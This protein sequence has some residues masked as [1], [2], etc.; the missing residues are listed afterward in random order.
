MKRIALLF[1]ILLLSLVRVGC[2]NTKTYYVDPSLI[3]LGETGSVVGTLFT[4][5]VNVTD[6]VN[7][8]GFDIQFSWNTTYLE[9]WSHVVKVPV[10]VYADGVLHEPVIRLMDDVDLYEGS[11]HVAYASLSSEGFNGSGTVFEMTFRVINQPY[12]Y[13]VPSPPNDYVSLPLQLYVQGPSDPEPS[14]DGEVRLYAIP[15]LLPSYPLLK[16][17]PENINGISVNETVNAE[18]W[19]MG[20]GNED[21][22]PF[23]DVS[24]FDVYLNFNSTVIEAVSVD[25]DPDGWFASFWEGGIDE[26]SAEIDNTTGSVRVIFNGTE[27]EHV[28]VYGQG[29]VFNVE[30]K[31]ILESSNY[32]PPA[33]VVGLRNPPPRPEICGIEAP[34]YVEGYQHPDRDWCPWYNNESRVA[35]PHYVENATYRTPFEPGILVS[36]HSPVPKNYSVEVIWFNVSA[37][38]PIDEWWYS[39]NSGSNVTFTPNTAIHVVECENNLTIYASSLGIE[40]S[41]SVQFYALT[42]DVDGDRDVDIYDVVE[43]CNCYGKEEGDPEYLLQCDIVPP[44][45]GN[46][47]IDIYDIVA[48]ANNYGKSC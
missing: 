17:I 10:E 42:G 47:I 27:G 40:G 28:P 16:V 29:V 34:V 3:V 31:P 8:Y 7:M 44:P 39:I 43:M 46:G 6:A 32:P 41:L 45:N 24:G 23:W 18:V 14:V 19:L 4:V 30:F 21:L 11:Y 1:S 12:A 5:G 15:S 22:P 37:N 13:E 38:I 20:T 33:S 35:L 9:Y 26:I 2:A 25:V 48:M 36:I